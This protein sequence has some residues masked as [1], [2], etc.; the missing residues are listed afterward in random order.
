[1][2]GL[3]RPEPSGGPPGPDPARSEDE[4]AREMIE[5]IA[6]EVD[7]ESGR[8]PL[9]EE[10]EEPDADPA[11]ASLDTGADA[12]SERSDE[13]IARELVERIAR[14]VDEDAGG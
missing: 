11:E 12:E 7:L 13:D 10:D 8:L 2:P 6:R 3:D 1:M 9:G 5:R 14:E 4:L